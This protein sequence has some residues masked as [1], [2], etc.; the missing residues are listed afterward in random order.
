MLDG[1]G[2]V[3]IDEYSSDIHINEI[4]TVIQWQIHRGKSNANVEECNFQDDLTA[5][6]Y[7]AC[8]ITL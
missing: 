4:S 8:N 1:L 5:K 3:W 2:L 7:D 6:K